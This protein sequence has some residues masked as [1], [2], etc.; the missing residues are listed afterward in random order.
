MSSIVIKYIRKEIR[1]GFSPIIL[2][3]GRQRTGKTATAMRL[4]YDIDNTWHPSLMTSKIEEFLHLYNDHS[5][6][7]L[8]LDEASIS[9]D[10]YEHMTITQRVYRHVIDTQAYKQNTIFIVLPFA[11]GIG[12]TA[13]DYVNMII[14]VKARGFYVAK[15]V[16]SQHD[17]LS[18]KPP[19]TWILEE[20]H[21]VPLPPDHIWK[22]YLEGGQKKYKEAIMDVQMNILNKKVSGFS[23][24]VI[25]D[26]I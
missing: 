10:P 3:V 17:D 16:F 9:L 22:P 7:I 8:I 21:G 5:K 18:F 19:Y 6:K 26:A 14:N 15:A 11:R 20:C 13:R 24:N 4:A 12:R 23:A 2:I 1:K 25:E